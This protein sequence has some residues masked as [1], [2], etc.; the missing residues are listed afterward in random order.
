LLPAYR[1][2]DLSPNRAYRL[3]PGKLGGYSSHQTRLLIPVANTTRQCLHPINNP[4]TAAVKTTISDPI[5]QHLCVADI[6]SVA[7]NRKTFVCHN[8]TTQIHE[9][10]SKLEPSPLQRHRHIRNMSKYSSRLFYTSPYSNISPPATSFDMARSI[11]RDS[12]ASTSSQYHSTSVYTSLVTSH[13]L[14][15]TSSSI[16][17]IHHTASPSSQP[18]SAPMRRTS[19]SSSQ[20]TWIASP[21][22]SCLTPTQQQT[23]TSYLSDDDLLCLGLPIETIPNPTVQRKEM[24]TEEQ[25][26]YLRDLQAQEEQQERSRRESNSSRRKVVRFEQSSAS[27]PRSSSRIKRRSTTVRKGM[28]CLNGPA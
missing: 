6:Q 15:H 22:G 21:Y 16:S 18:T 27:K 25:I 17:S 20:S 3:N 10:H 28:S 24:T 5:N 2:R 4:Q 12:T 8:R 13:P 14:S 7:S 26:K 23:P 1:Q 9:L 11:S 19:S